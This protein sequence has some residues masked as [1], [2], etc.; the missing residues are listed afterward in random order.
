[1]FFYIVYFYNLYILKCLQILLQTSLKCWIILRMLYVHHCGYYLFLL[2]PRL[3]SSPVRSIVQCLARKE[4][5]NEFYT[6]K[7]SSN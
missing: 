3:G 4:G 7:V 1:M 5:T 6:L 2:G